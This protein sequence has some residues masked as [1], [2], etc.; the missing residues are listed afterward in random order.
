MSITVKTNL[1]DFQRELQK[2]KRQ[3]AAIAASA[4]GA[5][6]REVAKAMRVQAVAGGKSPRKRTGTLK[7]AIEHFD[8]SLALRTCAGCGHVQPDRAPLV[9]PVA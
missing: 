7:A 3:M 2:I 8:A 4:T 6:A 9:D 5:A 1:P